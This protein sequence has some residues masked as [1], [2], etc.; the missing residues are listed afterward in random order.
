MTLKSEIT[1]IDQSYL[2]N[3]QDCLFHT[4]MVLITQPGLVHVNIY[5]NQQS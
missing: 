5:H 3:L 4:D 2:P 1:V